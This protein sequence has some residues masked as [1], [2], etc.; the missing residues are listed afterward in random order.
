MVCRLFA[1]RKEFSIKV[2]EANQASFVTQLAKA[3]GAKK[4]LEVG[5]TL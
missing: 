1:T 4:V 3:I 5:K 2:T